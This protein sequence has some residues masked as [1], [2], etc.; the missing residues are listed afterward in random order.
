MNATATAAAAGGL[1]V[2]LTLPL[3]S[4][5]AFYSTDA[6]DEYHG[7]YQALMNE[8]NAI[9]GRAPN[10][11]RQLASSNDV[12]SLGYLYLIEAPDRSTMAL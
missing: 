12:S 2:P 5:T 3:D 8:F 9:G 4:F 11:L 6:T 1:H 10:E 7:N